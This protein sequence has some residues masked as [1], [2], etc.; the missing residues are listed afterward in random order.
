MFFF[1]VGGSYY[2]TTVI[3]VLFYFFDNTDVFYFILNLA[4]AVLNMC[5]LYI[6]NLNEDLKKATQRVES[7]FFFTESVSQ[8]ELQGA[9]SGMIPK[10]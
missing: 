6:T 1:L 5:R 10:F 8:N 9:M 3:L 4:L 7:S 2:G